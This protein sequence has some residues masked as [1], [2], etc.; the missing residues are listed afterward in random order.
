MSFQPNGQC[1][2][3]GRPVQPPSEVLCA[4]CLKRLDEKMEALLGPY[5][6]QPPWEKSK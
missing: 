6:V 3:D 4:E 1:V 2:N 5:R